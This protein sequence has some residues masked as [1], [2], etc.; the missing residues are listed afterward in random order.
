M[1][2]YQ[3]KLKDPRWQKK[4]GIYLISI[5]GGAYIG[6]AVDLPKRLLSHLNDLRQSRHRNIHLQRAFR[7]YKEDAMDF[8]ILEIVDDPLNLINREQY[9]ID[10]MKPKYN[11]APIAG[12]QLGFRHSEKSKKLISAVQI[13]RVLSDEARKHI[14]EGQRGK[15]LSN[16][17]RLKLSMSKMGDKN[18]FYKAGTRHPQ[19][20]THRSEETKKKLSE[21][22]KKSG[23]NKG[24]KNP[25]S[26]SGTL[27]NN[28]TGE[29][30]RFKSLKP[31]AVLLGLNY[32]GLLSAHYCGRI[33][34][35]QWTV[36]YNH[37][38]RSEE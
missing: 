25:A 20:G 9:Y 2:T 37:R 38:H 6:S 19:Y 27:I 3:E 17:H 11:I 5:N 18:P 10:T 31:L 34:K 29:K 28:I 24:E 22:L 36:L 12:S 4:H 33:Y 21:T 13:G 30:R 8:D 14:S 26:R 35:K 16:A 1:T 32:K 15:K 23:A 7:K